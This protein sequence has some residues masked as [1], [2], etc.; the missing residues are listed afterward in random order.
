MNDFPSLSP[1][2]KML[3]YADDIIILHHIDLSTPDNLQADLDSVRLW[4]SSL[5]L[6]INADKLKAI[7]FRRS[8]ADPQG[9]RMDEVFAH[10]RSCLY[11][12]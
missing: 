5:K 7:T 6:R 11:R 9:L 1:N 10:S 4:V 2:S 8:A 3:A 12:Y